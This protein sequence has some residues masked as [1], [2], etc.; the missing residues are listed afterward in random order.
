MSSKLHALNQWVEATA[1]LTK[2]DRIHWCDGS[3]AEN[4][5]LST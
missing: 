2:P 1:K 3:D 5:T 4:R